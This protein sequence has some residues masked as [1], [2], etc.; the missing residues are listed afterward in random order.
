MAERV[1]S[2][3]GFQPL[4]ASLSFSEIS[5]AVVYDTSTQ[6]LFF[7]AISGSEGSYD[8]DFVAD[9][10]FLSGSLFA[11]NG[12][13]TA[14][15]FIGN[16]QTTIT[17]GQIVFSDDNVLAGN[18][19]FFYN[20]DTGNPQITI[21]GGSGTGQNARLIISGNRNA[22][23]DINSGLPRI[24]F[25]D[26]DTTLLESSSVLRLS[27]SIFEIYS[28][29]GSGK[30]QFNP[31]SGSVSASGHLYASLSFDGTSITD[32]LV[33]YDTAT[34][35]LFLTNSL[36]PVDAANENVIFK[37]SGLLTGS[38]TFQFTKLYNGATFEP[39][40]R[41]RGVGQNQNIIVSSSLTGSLIAYGGD[42]GRLELGNSFDNNGD[43]NRFYIESYEIGTGQKPNTL[44][45]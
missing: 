14:Q 20:Q 17:D 12:N 3:L 19:G 28:N 40:L 5:T 37:R 38:D 2:D 4:Y 35:Q 11:I 34:G 21:Q 33:A 22:G 13:I 45:S 7:G 24:S 26:T 43:T 27:G 42:R 32:N 18:S 9:N 1:R 15:N 30:V 6:Q 41:V 36:Q 8:I 44:R 39:T 23:V 31:V 16:L 10:I 25:T 29:Q